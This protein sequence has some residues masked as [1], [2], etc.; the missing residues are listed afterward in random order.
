MDFPRRPQ[1]LDSRRRPPAQPRLR[2][3]PP[4]LRD[5]RLLHEPDHRPN[6]PLAQR[7]GQADRRRHQVRKR[8]CVHAP[9]D[10]RREGRTPPPR[11]A[12]RP[13]D[14]PH[15]GP[16]R[17]HRRARG[18]PVQ[19]GSLSLLDERSVILCNSHDLSLR[20]SNGPEAISI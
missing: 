2:H 4:E 17:L 18:R 3:R 13:P 7:S 8:R 19:G 9:E 6:R 15:Q 16:G 20:G 12:R 10:S 14:D 5:E 1:H 11:K